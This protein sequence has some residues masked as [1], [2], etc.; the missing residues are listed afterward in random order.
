MAQKQQIELLE[1]KSFKWLNILLGIGIP[2]LSILQRIFMKKL[3]FLLAV[4][5]PS[6]AQVAALSPFS[7]NLYFGANLGVSK[8]YGNVKPKSFESPK[9]VVLEGLFEG[10]IYNSYSLPS[11]RSG[12][13]NY[14]PAA[15]FI[16]GYDCKLRDS[17]AVMGMFAS[18][19]YSGNSYYAPYTNNLVRIVDDAGS[20]QD[21]PNTAVIRFRGALATTAG[22]RFGFVA[23]S[24]VPFVKVGWMMNSI[25]A[26]MSRYASNIS[27]DANNVAVAPVRNDATAT[28][29]K[30][31]KKIHSLLVGL[32]F[33]TQVSKN[34]GAELST[35]LA[36]SKKATYNL[37]SVYVTPT[38]KDAAIVVP[39]FQFNRIMMTLKYT[40]P[41]CKN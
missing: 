12:W 21:S 23:G 16:L 37:G 30:A 31:G 7:S 39:K 3:F 38:Q 13:G 28:V 19:G 4:A 32:G 22:F 1:K 11:L 26:K 41:T 18:I 2:K 27:Y 35:D 15:E 34:F 17:A 36:F 33:L 5:G 20:T 10:S 24:V 6:F 40:M 14:S 25:A 9:P 29:Y 8:I